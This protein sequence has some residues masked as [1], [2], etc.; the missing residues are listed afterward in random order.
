MAAD[1]RARWN[2][3]LWK[4]TAESAETRRSRNRAGFFSSPKT[5]NAGAR[6]EQANYTAHELP[7]VPE[8]AAAQKEIARER[9]SREY[10]AE[11]AG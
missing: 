5:P 8:N 10:A 2:L 6:C 7:P 1:V 4:E 9:P 11:S 3:P